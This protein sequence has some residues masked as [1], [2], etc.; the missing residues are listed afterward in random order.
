MIAVLLAIIISAAFLPVSD[1]LFSDPGELAPGAVFG[2]YR[3]PFIMCAALIG[4][5]RGQKYRLSKYLYYL[6]DVLPAEA[7]D[8]FIDLAFEEA[9]KVG[10]TKGLPSG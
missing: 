8:A 6:L 7:R 2:A 1:L 9:Q 5:W 4:Y 10:P 3:L